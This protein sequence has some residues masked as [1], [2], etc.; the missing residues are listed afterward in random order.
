MRICR[1]THLTGVRVIVLYGEAETNGGSK[2][3][4]KAGSAEGLVKLS[5]DFDAPLDGLEEYG[6]AGNEDLI[7]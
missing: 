6:L 2:K 3:H 1:I 4:R 7:S 5:D